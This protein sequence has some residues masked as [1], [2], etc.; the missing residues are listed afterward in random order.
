[1]AN[2][3]ILL[4]F[5]PSFG[6]LSIVFHQNQGIHLADVSIGIYFCGYIHRIFR[7]QIQA[8]SIKRYK[9]FHVRPLL[10]CVI[11]RRKTSSSWAVQWHRTLLVAGENIIKQ[12]KSYLHF[13]RQIRPVLHGYEFLPRSLW[14]PPFCHVDYFAPPTRSNMLLSVFCLLWY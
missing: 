1:M 5:F 10:I 3:E 8:V 9:T 7:N 13:S 4:T 12:L 11:S 2:N 14:S 6:I